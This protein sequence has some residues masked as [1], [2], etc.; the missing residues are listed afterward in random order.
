MNGNQYQALI[1]DNCTNL[2]T[3]AATLTVN[4]PVSI[5]IQPAPASACRG[6]NKQFTVDAQGLSITYQWQMAP[7]MAQPGAI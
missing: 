3:N 7:I 2:S 6:E 4:Q 5:N 1:T